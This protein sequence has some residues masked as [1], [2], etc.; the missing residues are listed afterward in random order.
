MFE[1]GLSEQLSD[2]ARLTLDELISSLISGRPIDVQGGGAERHLWWSTPS[3][4]TEPEVRELIVALGASDQA[5]CQAPVPTRRAAVIWRPLRV[6]IE[7]FG[8]LHAHC[9]T[10]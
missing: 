6:E 4:V 5:A 8:G 10:E 2:V 3:N 9:T 1:A 7:Q